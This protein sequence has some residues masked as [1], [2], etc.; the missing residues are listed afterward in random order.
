V[1]APPEWNVQL[2]RTE[3][4]IGP[5]T[6]TLANAIN[7][8]RRR[9]AT[10]PTVT[11]PLR[12]DRAGSRGKL[13]AVKAAASMLS[14]PSAK[15]NVELAAAWLR[16]SCSCDACVHRNGQRLIDPTRWPANLVAADVRLD[17]DVLTVVWGPDGHVSRYSLQELTGTST[18]TSPSTVRLWDASDVEL[19]DGNHSSI[20]ADDA[21]LL[22]WL[23]G[24]AVMGCALL[25][26]VPIVDGE[27][28]RVAEL[29]AHVR[30][31]NYGR[32]FDVR[33]VVDPSNLADSALGLA[34][35]TDNPYRDP[36]PTMQ[37]LH[38]LQSSAV[39][40][41]NM[42]VDGWRVA[43]E[44]R[45]TDPRGFDLLASV[46]VTF[47]Y[48]DATAELVARA[49]IVETDRDGVV[50]AIRFNPRSM[51]PPRTTND[52]LA[53]W[54]EAYLAFARML[55]DPRHQVRFRLDPGDL[56]VVDNRRVLHGRAA[57]EPASGT[58]HLQG[59][60]ADIDGLHSTVAVLSR[61]SA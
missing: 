51:R 27:V 46:P 37:L 17:G 6:A 47:T 60:Y 49:S 5:T 20:T 58:R 38:C 15:G 28:A 14:V 41:E 59:C 11:V 31:T 25:H 8:A 18:S 19:P 2:A 61:T 9:F 33:S 30:E 26:G 54:Y 32:W 1:V 40:G 3:P 45:S 23:G 55:A 4:N 13:G 48:R 57:F 42:L 22:G 43:D 21:A 39:G 16:D 10:A 52:R 12:R 24:L 50:R 7:A 29:F 36:V 34:P 35:H 44:L 56:F 53:R